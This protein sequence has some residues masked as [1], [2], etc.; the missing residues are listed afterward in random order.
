MTLYQVTGLVLIAL[1]IAFNVVF[2]MLRRA[3]EYPDIL[4]KPTDEILTRFLAGGARLVTLWYAFAMTALLAIPMA[5][6]M[7]GVFAAEY[8]QIAVASAIIGT[9]SGVVQ[10]MG[11]L[12]WPLLVPMLAA[13]YQANPTQRET[14]GVVFNAFHQY[15][16]VVVGEHLGY[17]FTA[18]W[19]ILISIMMFT[20]PMFGALLGIF[21]II[22]AVGIL[23]GMLE[24]AG[25]KPAGAI[26]AISYVV[27]SLWL[28]I[29]GVI[30]ILA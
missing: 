1:P 21:G 2:F 19:T 14:I 3:F 6:L 9:L 12:R 22:A 28:I 13:Q 16:G 4:R 30:L 23:A 5:L 20:T 18:T 25:W 24:P 8:P 7:Q 26:N 29:S 11:L 17:L 27:W 10:A 15:I